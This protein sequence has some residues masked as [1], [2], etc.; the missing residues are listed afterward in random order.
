MQALKAQLGKVLPNDRALR[1]AF[2]VDDLDPVGRSDKRKQDLERD[3]LVDWRMPKPLGVDQKVLECK[4]KNGSTGADK[5]EFLD[6][7]KRAAALSRK[8]VQH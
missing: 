8:R 2:E 3:I 4:E 1:T 5:Q 6:L 7:V